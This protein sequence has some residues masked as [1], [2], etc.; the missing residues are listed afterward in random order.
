MLPRSIARG[1]IATTIDPSLHDLFGFVSMRFEVL[2]EADLTRVQRAS[3]RANCRAYR[4]IRG[5]KAL[6]PEFAG[7]AAVPVHARRDWPD[8]SA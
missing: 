1:T 7:Y 2:S 3:P 6:C 5:D 8:A 4:R